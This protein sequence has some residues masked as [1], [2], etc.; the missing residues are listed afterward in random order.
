MSN[1]CTVHFNQILSK[2]VQGYGRLTPVSGF[3]ISPPRRSQSPQPSVEFLLC[4]P[5]SATSGQAASL[6]AHLQEE[7]IFHCSLNTVTL[8]SLASF[9]SRAQL[10]RC[11]GRADRHSVHEGAAVRSGRQGKAGH[12]LQDQS[13]APLPADPGPFFT[14][15]SEVRLYIFLNASAGLL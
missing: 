13:P 2:Q 15:S 1:S 3:D 8:A 14:S 5:R 10:W 9:L 7:I 4:S 6:E 12:N 11:G